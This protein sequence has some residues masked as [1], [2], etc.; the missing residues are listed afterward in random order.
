VIPSEPRSGEVERLPPLRLRVLGKLMTFLVTRA[1]GLWPVLRGATRRFWERT[2][3]GWDTRVEPDRPEHLAALAGACE[4]LAEE[5]RRVLELGTGTGSGALYLARRYQRA[6]VVGVDISEALVLRA[7]EKVREDL[8]D[9]VR[10]A[11]ADAGSLP[12]DDG[13]FDLVVQLNL[14][15]YFGEAAR[16]LSRGGRVVVASS[17]GAATPYH[18]PDAVL[19]KGFERRRLE[20]FATGSAGPGSFF[21]ARRP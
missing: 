16:V 10:F 2:A 12:F 5:P 7:Q 15:A 3:A 13:E 20:V 21:I 4:R 14:P 6:E 19:R 8:G 18:T 1:P 9:R 17:L 11:V